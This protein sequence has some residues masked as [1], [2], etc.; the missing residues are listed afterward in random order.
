[1]INAV[2][3]LSEIKKD[4]ACLLGWDNNPAMITR[5]GDVVAYVVSPERMEQLI[6]AEN[7]M[8]RVVQ[9]KLNEVAESCGIKNI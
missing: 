4:P 8:K 5:Y 1:M 3:K 6:N 7:L 2:F 9:E